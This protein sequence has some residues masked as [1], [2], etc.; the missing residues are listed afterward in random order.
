MSRFVDL[1]LY[2]QPVTMYWD[3]EFPPVGQ[4][5][6]DEA[7]RLQNLETLWTR[8]GRCANFAKL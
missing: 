6:E 2:K 5:P 3:L 1:E 8:V 7:L 4:S